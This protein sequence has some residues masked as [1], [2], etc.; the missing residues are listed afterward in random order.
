MTDSVPTPD[1]CPIPQDAWSPAV[2]KSA[3]PNAP[4]PLR[5]MAARGMAPM[6]AADLVFSQFVLR[7][8]PDPKVAQVA[9]S[10]LASLDPRLANAVLSDT[11]VHPAVLGHLAAAHSTNE[12]Y[13]EKLLLNSALP[14]EAVI[15]VAK[16]CSERIV[17]DL[18]VTNQARL[19]KAPEIAR[20]LT[21]N[22]S[23]LKSD[24]DRAI[25]FLVRNGQILDGV[26]E[27][28]D[29]LLRLTGED[30]LKAADKIDLPKELIDEKFL[31]DE[32]RQK[33]KEERKFITD[34]E[35]PAESEEEQNLTIE[36]RLRLMTVAEKVAFAT[37]GNKSVR[38]YLMRDTNRMVAL[39]AITSPAISE[40][41]VLAAANSKSVHQDVIDHIFRD[42][43]NNWVRNYQVKL[44]LVNNPKTQLPNAMK[45]VPT[46]NAK[47][48]KTVA[49]SRNVPMG[50]RNLA[51]NLVKAKMK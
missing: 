29:A 17:S 5:M 30:R 11:K 4:A 27:F 49:K 28:E 13:I 1:T 50:V 22:P 48:L 35:E 7:W 18:I 32:D 2:L 46:L 37:K 23:A 31:S 41:E 6:P 21:Q 42:K 20:S 43:K 8:D 16:R 19:L 24:V 40:Q 34:E 25:D 3:G 12:A 45:L 14:V 33:L 9:E 39:A 26:R 10:S 38:S 51:N 44:A 15:E 36:Q 47:D